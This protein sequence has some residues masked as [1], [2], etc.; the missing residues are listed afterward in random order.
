[1]FFTKRQNPQLQNVGSLVGKKRGGAASHA[2][3]S[4]ERPVHRSGWAGGLEGRQSPPA[5]GDCHRNGIWAPPPT[6]PP[7]IQVF[8]NREG[9]QLMSEKLTEQDKL[10]AGGLSRPWAAVETRPDA[11]PGC[12]A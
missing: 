6:R 8:E 4:L 12:W 9:S 2:P 5:T 7:N 11:G 3:R 1:M 10:E